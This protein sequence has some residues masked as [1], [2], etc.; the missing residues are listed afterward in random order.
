ME[1]ILPPLAKR[2]GVRRLLKCKDIKT[3]FLKH[4]QAGQSGGFGHGIVLD[5]IVTRGVGAAHFG[6]GTG[7]ALDFVGYRFKQLVRGMIL[8]FQVRSLHE[9]E[10]HA[11][12][13][14]WISFSNTIKSWYA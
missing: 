13:N 4:A 1:S 10:E 3:L 5:Q 9:K 8:F 2:R 6:T 14:G 12:G 11:G 7:D